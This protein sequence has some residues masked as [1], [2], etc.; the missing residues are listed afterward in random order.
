MAYLR[1]CKFDTQIAMK[2]FKMFNKVRLCQPK[3]ILPIGKGPLDYM[4]YYE[5]PIFALLKERNP[6]DGT[7]VFVYSFRNFDLEEDDVDELFNAVI[8]ILMEIAVDPSVQT[9]G[10]RALIDFTGMRFAI[11]KSAMGKMY[12]NK[13]RPSALYLQHF[14]WTQRSLGIFLHRPRGC[15]K[16]LGPC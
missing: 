11:M 5:K 15:F 6:L 1:T 13:V 7:V 14:F 9:Y 2:R 4:K 3:R 12:Y 16:N 8:S 10:V